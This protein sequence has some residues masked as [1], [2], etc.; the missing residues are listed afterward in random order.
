MTAMG[1][2][3]GTPTAL[4]LRHTLPKKLFLGAKKNALTI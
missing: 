4:I 2:E 3:A 1:N